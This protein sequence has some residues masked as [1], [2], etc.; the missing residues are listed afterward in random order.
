MGDNNIAT[1]ETHG[2][3]SNWSLQPCV[4]RV[5]RTDLSCSVDNCL[6]HF[7]SSFFDLFGPFRTPHNPKSRTKKW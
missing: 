7:Q 3:W 1:R 2:S 4:S 5:E 6:C